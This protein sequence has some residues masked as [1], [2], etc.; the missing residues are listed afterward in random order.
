MSDDIRL[1]EN[2]GKGAWI[3]LSHS[4]KDI[5]E[6]RKYRN[7]LEKL[8]HNPLMFFLKCLDN[9]DARLP[10]L[11]RDEI[12]ARQWF[13]LCDSPS[14]KVSKWVQEEVMIIKGIDNSDKVFE[15]I[16]LRN[17]LNENLPKLIR[18]SKRARIFLS[19]SHLDYE[20]AE[21]IRQVLEKHDFD[22]WSPSAI[23]PGVEFVEAIKSEIDNSLSHGFVLV[24]L[25]ELSLKS[26]WCRLETKYA[27]QHAAASRQSNVIPVII[28][29]FD[30]SLLPPELRY[31]QFFDL[32]KGPFNERMSE[33]IKDLKSREME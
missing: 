21:R 12:N 22:V 28:K 1:H 27:L 29:Q 10:E 18:L 19:Y 30:L 16:D 17:D 9:D 23:R 25:S 7:E 3:F 13:V 4:N 26:K 31:I 5:E 11:I 8:G 6:V 24:L 2:K 32:N 14:A 33:L 20:T 15:I